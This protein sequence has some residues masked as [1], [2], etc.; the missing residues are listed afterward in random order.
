MITKA[1]LELVKRCKPCQKIFNRDKARNRYRALKGIPLDKPVEKI[2]KKKKKEKAP[3]PTPVAAV[4]E[5]PKV[6]KPA[7]TPEEEARRQK[8][9]AK[10]FDM[11]GDDSTDDDW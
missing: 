3:E 4:K 7:L 5:E 2:I 10:L 6:T 9:L 8:A 11:L 1:C